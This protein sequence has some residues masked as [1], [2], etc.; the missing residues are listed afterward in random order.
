MGTSQRP[1]VN[2][3]DLAAAL[4]PNVVRFTPP[5]VRDEAIGPHSEWAASLDLIDQAA[6]HFKA[7]EQRATQAEERAEKVA[8]KA[9]E[10]LRSAQL[11]VEHAEAQARAVEEQ[12]AE[13]LRQAQA[14]AEE[15]EAWAR[16]AEERAQDAEERARTAE[17]RMEEIE[18]RL[19]ATEAR[20][21]EAEEWLQRLGGALRQKLSFAAPAEAADDHPLR[22]SA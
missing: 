6:A 2:I 18:S 10:G 3:A 5:P 1:T 4:G 11:R 13:D 21:R 9:I 12:A 20:A 7:S 14:R 8:F 16:Q 22:R 17:S 19:A 15:A